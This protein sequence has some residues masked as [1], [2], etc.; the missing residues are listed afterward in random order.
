[1]A[2]R[3]EP[4]EQSGFGQFFDSI[5]LLVL[6]YA[7][8]LIP[9]VMGLTASAI[10]G[11]AAKMDGEI[12]W[13]RLGQNPTMQGQWE[14]LGFDPESAAEIINSKFD[15]SIDPVTLIITALVIFGYFFFVVRTS[16]KE[17]REVIAEKFDGN[18]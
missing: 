8:L 12:T 9:V 17:Y 18:N 2:E 4:P 5:F 11:E 10:G 1:M 16:D 7:S 14:K 15:Y 3:Y 6:V 13:E